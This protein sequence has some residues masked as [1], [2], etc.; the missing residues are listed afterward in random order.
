MA[1][2]TILEQA[3]I[4]QDAKILHRFLPDGPQGQHVVVEFKNPYEM[5]EFRHAM[6][7]LPENL[8]DSA[9]LMAVV[10]IMNIKVLGSEA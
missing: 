10:A 6:R 7:Q 1:G 4:G 8:R 9:G 3:S 2:E 5:A